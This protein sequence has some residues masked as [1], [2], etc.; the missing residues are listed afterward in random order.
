MKLTHS[1]TSEILSNYTSSS[2]GLVTLQ[3]LPLSMCITVG[4]CI[5]GKLLDALHAM[6]QCLFRTLFL[7]FRLLVSIK[8][9][10]FE[11]EI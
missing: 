3:Y 10:N 5:Y 8:W 11:A 7:C 9:R 1:H 4:T 2:E 6:Q